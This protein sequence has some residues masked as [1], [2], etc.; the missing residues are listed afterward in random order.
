MINRIIAKISLIC[1]GIV[2]AFVIF[3][4]V[5]GIIPA[6]GVWIVAALLGGLI[7]AILGYN[8]YQMSQ[9]E[10]FDFGW[11]LVFRKGFWQMI[12]GLAGLCL[13]VFGMFGVIAPHLADE[14]AEKYVMT[15]AKMLVILFWTALTSTFFGWELICLSESVAYLRL[16][17]MDSAVGSFALGILWL[18]FALLFLYLFLEVINDVFYRLSATA[19]N[20]ILI[21]FSLLSLLIGLYNGKFEDLNNLEEEK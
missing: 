14:L 12:L 4:G 17:K 5:V 1:W 3:F 13:F 16:K 20:W 11:F 9:K 21:I 10:G 18:L 8:F 19:Q 6:S 7:L 2:G 15:F